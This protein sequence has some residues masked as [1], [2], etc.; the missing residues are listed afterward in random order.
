MAHAESYF[1]CSEQRQV[2]GWTRQA[3][4]HAAPARARRASRPR[5]VPLDQQGVSQIPAGASGEAR[6]FHSKLGS[7][8]KR[9]MQCSM[10]EGGSGRDRMGPGLLET[11]E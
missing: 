1:A 11:Q 8:Y 4:C 9:G 5:C 2:R 6:G 3:A 10:G 7:P